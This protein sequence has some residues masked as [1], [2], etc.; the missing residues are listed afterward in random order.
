MTMELAD[1]VV[2]VVAVMLIATVAT[3]TTGG[4]MA[5]QQRNDVHEKGLG[6][7]CRA[8]PGMAVCRAMCHRQ[9]KR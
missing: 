7:I 3:T 5:A 9:R 8:K 2:L 1:P 4:T 6:R